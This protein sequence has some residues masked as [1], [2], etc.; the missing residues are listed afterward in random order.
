MTLSFTKE[1]C[2]LLK[3]VNLEHRNLNMQNLLYSWHDTLDKL[4]YNRDLL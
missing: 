1:K 3:K 4:L 2:I